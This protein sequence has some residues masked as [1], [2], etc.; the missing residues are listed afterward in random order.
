MQLLVTDIRFLTTTLIVLAILVVLVP[1][2]HANNRGWLIGFVVLSWGL[3]AASYIPAYLNRIGQWDPQQFRD[4]ISGM[5]IPLSLVGVTAWLLLLTYAIRTVKAGRAAFERVLVAGSEQELV[6][7]ADNSVVTVT[8][9]GRDITQVQACAQNRTGHTLRVLVSPGTCFASSGTHQNMVATEAT[10]FTLEPNGSQT[11]SMRAAC[12][13]ASRPIPGD[14]D[15]FRGVYRVSPMLAKF[16]EHAISLSPMA[17][18]AGVWALTDNYSAGDVQSHLVAR[19]HL[20]NQ[21]PAVSLTDIAA[22]RKVLDDIGASHR[23]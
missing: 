7:L 8:A 11:F 6:D 1:A 22:A 20:G 19:D 14:T 3:S 10:R 4:F 21:R 23:L 17:R 9:T 12:V 15:H 16:L 5:T 13:N 18:Q 2:R